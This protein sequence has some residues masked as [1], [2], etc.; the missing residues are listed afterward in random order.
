VDSEDEKIVRKGFGFENG[1]AVRR[2]K[3]PDRLAS[4]EEEEKAAR[5]G[6]H[7]L[8]FMRVLFVRR[9]QSKSERGQERGRRFFLKT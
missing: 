8:R 7:T 2:W 6:R 4:S 1:G 9:A 5:L 3:R